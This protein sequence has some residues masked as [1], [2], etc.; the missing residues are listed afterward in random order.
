MSGRFI[1]SLRL[2]SPPL[3]DTP[4]AAKIDIA[5][6]ILRI[7]SASAFLYH[8]S[9]ILFGAFGGPGPSQFADSHHWPSF[10]GFL[11]GLAEVAGG[12]AVLSGVLFRLGAACIAVVMVGAIFLVHLPH[13]CEFVEITGELDCIL[14]PETAQEFVGRLTLHLAILNER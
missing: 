14:V 11:V 7:T 9:G 1:A 3:T 13:G 8:G 12:L 4:Y 2:D 10:I 6:L 5:L